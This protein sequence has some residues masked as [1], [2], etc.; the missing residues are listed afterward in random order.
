MAVGRRTRRAMVG[1]VLA[2][3]LAGAAGCGEQTSAAAP[4]AATTHDLATL[5]PALVAAAE[6]QGTVH[7]AAEADG[8]LIEGDVLV[9]SDPP[10]ADVTMTVT[11]D[12]ADPWSVRMVRHDGWV[13]LSGP[14]TDGYQRL[15]PDDERLSG[16]A[17]ARMHEDVDPLR[18]LLRMEDGLTGVEHVGAAEVD[19]EPL[20]HYRLTVDHTGED[21]TAGGLAAA[22]E[23]VVYDVLVDGSDLLRRFT[24]TTPRGN[25][26]THDFTGW[27]DPVEIT[28][29]P[30]DQ[31][32]QG[33]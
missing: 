30:A 3:A 20:G 29:P 19:G 2:L 22:A 21:V 24:W 5:M 7:G 6:E 12:E 26:V 15:A 16:A 32:V 18:A 25:R 10:E 9:G 17:A 8:V 1:F 27:G 31:V 23:G 4:E 14:D 28:A 13:Y 33:G 11:L